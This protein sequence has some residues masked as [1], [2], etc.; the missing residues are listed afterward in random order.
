[1]E[2]LLPKR[3]KLRR[4]KELP[5]LTQ[6]KLDNTDPMRIMPYTEKEL[7]TR[8]MFLIDMLDPM[9]MKS[10]ALNVEPNRAMP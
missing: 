3:A 8:I 7:P 9:A 4:D 2:R 5:S 1:M 6:S 10:N